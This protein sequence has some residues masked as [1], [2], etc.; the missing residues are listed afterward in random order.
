ML[1][2][3]YTVDYDEEDHGDSMSPLVFD[4]HVHT[5]ADKY[6]YPSLRHGSLRRYGS[7]RAGRQAS[8]ASSCAL[9]PGERLSLC[10]I[11]L[12]IQTPIASRYDI[13]GLGKLAKSR[14]D[15][16][17]KEEWDTSGF[18]EAAA[19]V[20]TDPAVPDDFRETV[21]AVATERAKELNEDDSSFRQT[22]QKIPALGAALWA[23]VVL[24]EE[25]KPKEKVYKCPHNYGN[26]HGQ[27][28]TG[29]LQGQTRYRC[30]YCGNT[31]TVAAWLASWSKQEGQSTD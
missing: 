18:A 3:I 15:E 23:K 20:F 8:E 4:A 21:V 2:Y 17:A 7:R 27:A 1:C 6:V 22:A 13:P 25:P 24:A 30:Q 12:L 28:T 16:R 11:H 5:I 9:S 26:C 14:F 29:M 19:L 10:P 31:S